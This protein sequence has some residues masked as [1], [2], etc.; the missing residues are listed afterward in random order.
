MKH[1]STVVAALV[2]AVVANA[3]FTDEVKYDP[4]A[5]TN[6]RRANMKIIAIKTPQNVPPDVLAIAEAGLSDPDS[7]VRQHAAAIVLRM[8]AAPLY[9][10]NIDKI[11]LSVH[12]SLKDRLLAALQDEDEKVRQIAIDAVAAG[13]E[14]S[15]QL[16]SLLVQRF[17]EESSGANRSRLIQCLSKQKYA[18][19]Q[20]AALLEQ[21]LTDEYPEVRGMAAQR[22]AQIKSS[23]ALP[24]LVQGMTTQDPYVRENFQR[25]IEAYGKAARSYLPQ[26]EEL[27]DQTS[28]EV[29]QSIE[30]TINAIQRQ[31]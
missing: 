21:A 2:L 29:R 19:P 23:A 1:Y 11:D 5:D 31:Q 13:V 10:P 18:S 30:R 17:A 6:E 7:E 25:A 24:R 27:K 3:A 9:F 14:P 12:P 8:A 22:V 20:I 4:K 26:L 16:E 28:N 15:P